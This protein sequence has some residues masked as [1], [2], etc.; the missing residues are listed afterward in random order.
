MNFKPRAK[1]ITSDDKVRLGV[2]NR[3]PVH[4]EILWKQGISMALNNVLKKNSK[5][6]QWLTRDNKLHENPVACDTAEVLYI[7]RTQNS[8]KIKWKQ[9]C[10]ILDP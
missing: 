5:N 1:D 4:A 8:N 2:V 3:D 6:I 10:C 9:S 7:S